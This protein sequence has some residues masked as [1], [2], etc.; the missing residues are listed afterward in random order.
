[1]HAEAC[2]TL[3][4][5]LYWTK[6]TPSTQPNIITSNRRDSGSKILA[7]AER[8]MTE[9][10]IVEMALFSRVLGA[11]LYIFLPRSSE[12]SFRCRRKTV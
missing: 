9:G 12:D 2:R 11:Q 3:I 7:R 6:W 4:R 1:M 10:S 5:W 8:S